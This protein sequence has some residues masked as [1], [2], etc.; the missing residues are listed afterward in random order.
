MARKVIEIYDV[1][2]GG[3]FYDGLSARWFNRA[4][5]QAEAEAGEDPIE[6]R[7]NSPGGSITEGIAMANRISR[8][9]KTVHTYIDGVAFSMA[10][11]IAMHGHKI[12][13]AAN[14]SIMIHCA[15][16][17]SIGNSRDMTATA[18][19]LD[20]IDTGLAETVAART[21]MTVA[22]VKAK[23]FDYTDH[24]LTADEAVAAGLVDEKI[25]IKIKDADNLRAMT[26]EQLYAHF[27]G[28]K[29]NDSKGVFNRLK[30]SVI[31][32]LRPD[33]KNLN[34][35]PE[36]MNLETLQAKLADLKDGK[37]DVSAEDAQA[38]D[39]EI[40]A[41]LGK[42][43]VITEADLTA[44]AN[45]ART[46]KDAEIQTLKDQIKALEDAAGAPPAGGKRK[47]GDSV[48]AEG[49]ENEEHSWDAEAEKKG[50]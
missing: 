1:I 14:G 43:K 17:G 45:N 20:S 48:G 33:I 16:G 3:Y 41:A 46:E 29:S 10:G 9:T 18:Q 13:M 21:N 30:E 4:M 50:F 24:T 47:K 35:K 37:L 28:Q 26:I 38:I 8:S 5:D 23:W 2:G 31:A 44:A 15:S 36:K 19:T 12:Y 49:E 27:T 25:P 6:V 22:E 32:A 11:I 39:A 7:I 40:K 34:L 42:G